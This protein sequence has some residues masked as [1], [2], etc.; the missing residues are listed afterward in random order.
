MSRYTLLPA[1]ALLI[2]FATQPAAAD[3]CAFER[4]NP[5]ASSAVSNT[6]GIFEIDDFSFDVEQTLNI[7]SQT[8]GSGAGKVTFNPF[9]ITKQVDSST[10][11][12]F[13]SAIA[14]EA[15]R[16]VKCTFYS[17]STSNA[18]S[19]PYLTAL[20]TNAIIS[21]FKVEGSADGIPRAKFWFHYEKVEWKY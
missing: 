14:G 16:E 5:T 4:S 1:T 8:S 18:T 2:A 15:F 13:E 10:P 17:P 12:L 11:Q 9:Q 3:T 19:S 21:K 6:G 7:G 20:F